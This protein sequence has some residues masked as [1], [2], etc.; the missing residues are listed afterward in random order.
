MA[1]R[2]KRNAADI[3]FSNYIRE[4]AGWQCERCG[5]QFARSNARYL[6]CSHNW[7]RGMSNLRYHPDNALALCKNCHYWFEHYRE[8]STP[9][10]KEKLGEERYAALLH[11]M[12]HTAAPPPNDARHIRLQA[13]RYRVLQRNL[14][15]PELKPVGLTVPQEQPKPKPKPAPKPKL[16]TASHPPRT[17]AD[18]EKN[19]ARPSEQTT[20]SKGGCVVRKENG[21]RRLFESMLKHYPELKG[22]QKRPYL[23]QLWQHMADLP[24]QTEPAAR[25]TKG[26]P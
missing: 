12:E 9:W 16:Q 3:A 2:I 5:M 7:H 20:G 1:D 11:D 14:M 6:H 22:R 13:A 25:Q 15:P 26:K 19:P 17:V 8:Q 24:P 23:F 10:L 18:A 4:R 21:R